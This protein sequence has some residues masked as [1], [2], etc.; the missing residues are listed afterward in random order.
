MSGGL[1]LSQPGAAPGGRGTEFTF[2]V[3]IFMG[4]GPV[5]QGTPPIARSTVETLVL[6]R[7]NDGEHGWRTPAAALRCVRHPE[8]PEIMDKWPSLKYADIVRLNHLL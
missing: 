1:F 8:Q 5:S 2:Q 7:R 4:A 3:A 6:P